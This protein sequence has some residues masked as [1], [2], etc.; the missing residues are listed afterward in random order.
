MR[1]MISLRKLVRTHTYSQSF[2]SLFSLSRKLIPCSA[3]PLRLSGLAVEAVATS[4]ASLSNH[5]VF[6]D[7]GEEDQDGEEDASTPPSTVAAATSGGAGGGG[8]GNPEDDQLE[9][10]FN[11][12]WE[13][14]DAART[15]FGKI[16]GPKARLQEAECLVALG[17]LSLETGSL[18][19]SLA[20]SA[21]L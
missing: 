20:R 10:D 6:E 21:P 12:A 18:Y 8:E 3:L 16:E 14:L 13:V 17:D 5:F 9:D 15:L 19:L 7:E 2:P 4:A 1:R 11:A